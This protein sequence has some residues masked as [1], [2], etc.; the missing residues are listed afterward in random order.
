LI[1][2]TLSALIVLALVRTSA[3]VEA[4]GTKRFGQLH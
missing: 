3:E 4:V 1:S 2:W